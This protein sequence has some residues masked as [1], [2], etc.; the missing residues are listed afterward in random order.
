MS[1]LAVVP[2][3][4]RTR[5]LCRQAHVRVSEQKFWKIKIG[6]VCSIHTFIVILPRGL[7]PASMS[8]NTITGMFVVLSK[9]DASHWS[10]A[11]CKMAAHLPRLLALTAEP[12]ACAPRGSHRLFCHNF[13]TPTH[14]EITAGQSHLSP[15]KVY[16]LSVLLDERK[17]KNPRRKWGNEFSNFQY[18]CGLRRWSII[19]LCPLT[20]PLLRH[21]RFSS[22]LLTHT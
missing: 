17:T 22:F 3:G 15:Y 7:P 21:Y 16:L 20:K 4:C 5:S 2:H 11:M 12:K 6:G 19:E 10:N 13:R 14:T 1:E 9:Q 8:K 18:I